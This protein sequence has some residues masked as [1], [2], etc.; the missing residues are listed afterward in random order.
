MSKIGGWDAVFGRSAPLDMEIGFGNGEYLARLSQSS[1]ERDFVG[2]E[3]SWNSMKRALRRLYDPPRTN[4]K[5]M[6]LAARPALELLFSPKSL[7]IIRALFP[8]PWPNEK[9]AKRRMF[10]KDFLNLIAN[11]LKD[12]GQFYM[13][14]DNRV[15]T[16]WT[17]DQ[18]VG[19]D[20][21]LEV[22]EQQA[23]LNT[24]YER[25]WL[26]GGQRNFFHII[27]RKTGHP[28][29]SASGF[30]EMKPSYSSSINPQNYR[31]ENRTG[32]PTVIFGGFIYDSTL[33]EGLLA[34][35][36]IE[37]QF[38]QEFHIRVALTPEGRWKLAPALA[39]Q[40]FPTSGVKLALALA[41]LEEPST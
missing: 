25:K 24:K 5:I 6:R 35:K 9:Q 8:V 36:V 23:M 13:V 21:C 34:A 20:L 19:T 15:L 32:D 3:V 17:I 11:R 14:T 27:G 39:N 26:S 40:V 4:V 28:H 12:D 7:S 29:L 18:A 38:I 37:D 22:N 41:T 31:P 10:D 16:D 1:W 33:K 2:L 30:N